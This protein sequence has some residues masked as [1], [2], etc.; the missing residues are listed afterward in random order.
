VVQVSQ[1]GYHPKQQNGRSLNW[2]ADA[3]RP[4]IVLSRVSESGALE[5]VLEKPGDAWGRFLRFD[6]LRLDFSSVERPG[7]SSQ[8][9]EVRSDPFRIGADV[10]ARG[11]WQ[12]TLEHFLPVQ[13]CHMRVNDRY[14]VWHDVCHLDD[15]RMAPVG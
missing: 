3:R 8:Y 9:G 1:V 4:P 10:F 7:M 2:I 11:V 14:R 15:A 5:R 13:M 6:Y 12:P